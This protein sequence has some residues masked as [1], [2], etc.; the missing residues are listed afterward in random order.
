MSLRA[1]IYRRVAI[2]RI[3]SLSLLNRQIAAS[4]RLF[5]T[6]R[7]DEYFLKKSNVIANP[8]EIGVKQSTE[9]SADVNNSTDCHGNSNKLEFTRNDATIQVSL[10]IYDALG[11]EVATL[12][13]KEQAPGKYSVQF[14]ANSGVGELSSGVYFY[15]LRAGNF[16][17]TR[18]M[19]L[20][21]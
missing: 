17:Q 18:K 12:V 4:S 3:F 19:L 9:T 2:Y 5:G 15:T 10:K 1:P 21:K 14:N 16:T 7:N 11:R 20:L 8:D 6:P 13:N